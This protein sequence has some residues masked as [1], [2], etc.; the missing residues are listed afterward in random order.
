MKK[1]IIIGAGMAGL[2]AGIHAQANGYDTVIFEMHDLPGGLC[3]SWKRGAYLIDGCIHWLCGSSGKGLLGKYLDEVGLLTNRKFLDR[4]ELT[5]IEVGPENDRRWFIAYTDRERFNRHMKELSPE[6]AEEID[7]FTALMEKF[8]SFPSATDKP[9]ELW[10]V[11]DYLSMIKT[12]KPFMKEFREY[13]SLT[14]GEYAKRFSGV[15]VREG[16]RNILDMPDFSFFALLMMLAWH[17][18]D[19]AGYLLGGSLAVSKSMEDTYRAMGGTLRYNARVEKILV[20]KKRAVGIRLS[21]GSEYRGDEVISCADGATTI[22]KMLD[23]RFTNRTLDRLYRDLPLFT[24]LLCVSLGINRDMGTEPEMAVHYLDKPVTLEGRT[25]TGIGVK[26]YGR[27]PSMAPKGK[28]LV[29]I[30]YP[31]D[32]TYW[33]ELSADRNRYAAEKKKAADTVIGALEQIYP[34]ISQDIEMTDVATPL[35]WERYTGNRNGTFEGWFINPKTMMVTIPKTLPGLK[36][37]WMAGQWVQPGGGIVTCIKSGRDIVYRLCAAD[38][39]PCSPP[40]RA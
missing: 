4:E 17:S 31:S 3:T 12:M 30:M 9:R 32:Y 36:N 1:I 19:N 37:F 38:R 40:K 2:S 10:G 8:V 23:G 26:H 15:H 25:Q 27:D 11:G 28:A 39:K 22:Y 34:G 14:V 24:P 16:I 21:D 20:E 35:T 29:E 6:D 33:K 5:R 18:T 7:R 13:G